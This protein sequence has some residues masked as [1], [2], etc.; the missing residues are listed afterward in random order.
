MIGEREND[1]QDDTNTEFRRGLQE[2][3]ER[4]KRFNKYDEQP[5]QYA[6]IIRANIYMLLYLIESCVVIRKMIDLRER[7]WSLPD[8][9]SGSLFSRRRG[10]ESTLHRHS[11]K[12]HV[13]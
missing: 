8:L 7:L 1:Q 4:R 3:N 5:K 10:T 2:T 9:E 12:N 13:P 11:P 6:L